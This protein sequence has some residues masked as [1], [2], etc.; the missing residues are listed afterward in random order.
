LIAGERSGEVVLRLHTHTL[1]EQIRLGLLSIPQRFQGMGLTSMR[2]KLFEKT[3]RLCIGCRG[4]SV[5]AKKGFSVTP[6]FEGVGLTK[7]QSQAPKKSKRLVIAREG[8]AV[9]ALRLLY[10]TCPL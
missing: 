7:A 1:G 6:G 4:P 5:V 3:E 2:I 9:I 8:F 10:V